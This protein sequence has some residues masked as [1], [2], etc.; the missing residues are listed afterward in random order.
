ME[1]FGDYARYYNLLYADKEYSK[2][3]DFVLERF[4]AAGC[5]FSSLLDLGCGTGRHALCMAERGRAVTGVDQSETMLEMGRQHINEAL[6]RQ[7][8]PARV[9]MPELL[10]GDAREIRLGRTF[11]AVT[12]LFHVM[13]YQNSEQDALALFATARSHLPDGGMFLFDFWHGPGVLSEPPTERDR[14][15]EDAHTRVERH[16]HPVQRLDDNL[17]EVHYTIKLQDKQTGCWKQFKEMHA[18]RYWFMPELR[19]LAAEAGFTMVDAG[20][21]MRPGRA[22]LHTWNAWILVKAS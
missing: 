14:I 6:A 2:E 19:F 7:P 17:V 4:S 11:T 21:W 9:P 5:R 22:D 16:A 12:S 10:L 8:L 3:T 13:S 1:V 18:M 15:M 20:A